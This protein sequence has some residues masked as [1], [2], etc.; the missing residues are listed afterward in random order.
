MTHGGKIRPDGRVVRDMYLA[1]VKT[2][3]ESRGEWDVYKILRTLPGEALLPPPS[4][5]AC[6]TAK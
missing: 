2:K 3:A 4:E 1:Q 6:A 5:T